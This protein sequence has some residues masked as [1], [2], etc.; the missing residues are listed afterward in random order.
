MKPS[1]EKVFDQWFLEILQGKNLARVREYA[2]SKTSNPNNEKSLKSKFKN[3]CEKWKIPTLG[4]YSR[5]L[6]DEMKNAKV[7]GVSF[8]KYVERSPCFQE[9]DMLQK[10]EELF[11]L[12]QKIKE[13]SDKI[14][15]PC[16]L[17][18]RKS[19]NDCHSRNTISQYQHTNIECDHLS[20]L[21]KNSCVNDCHIS[22]TYRSLHTMQNIAWARERVERGITYAKV[23]NFAKAISCYDQ[24]NQMDPAC[25]DA[26]VARGAAYANENKLRKAAL[27]FKKALEL[28]AGRPSCFF[29]RHN[30][31]IMTLILILTLNFLFYRP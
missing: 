5:Y 16:K 1:Q 27:Q 12:R 25:A 3:A 7:E 17:S 22:Y 20:S 18:N 10:I 30:F 31:P 8:R 23:G 6:L 2:S 19:V 14:E 9:P 4:E 24:A 28:D 29:Y 21:Q 15:V 11:A 13:G 26:Y